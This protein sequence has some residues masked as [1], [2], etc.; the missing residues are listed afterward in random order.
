MKPCSKCQNYMDDKANEKDYPA[1]GQGDDLITSEALEAF[2]ELFMD[3]KESYPTCDQIEEG[4]SGN[5]DLLAFQALQW[6]RG[7]LN[8][9][10]VH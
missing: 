10:E 2:Q 1:S 4:G 7:L 9:W 6:A 3:W 5:T 8:L